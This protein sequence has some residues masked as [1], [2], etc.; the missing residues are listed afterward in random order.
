MGSLIKV[1]MSLGEGVMNRKEVVVTCMESPLYFTM[2]LKRR[3]QFVKMRQ[4]FRSTNGLREDLITWVKTG[5][6][7]PSN[8]E[9]HN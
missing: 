1:V 6:L 5:H 4:R 3:L 2:P 7:Y 8:Q 9:L